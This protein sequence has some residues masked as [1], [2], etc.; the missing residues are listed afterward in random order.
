MRVRGSMRVSVS[1]GRNG[2]RRGR[3]TRGRVIAR[4]KGAKKYAKS[5]PTV[6]KGGRSQVRGD[7]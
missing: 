4:Y 2:S 5:F 6:G 3:G 1:W 7:R